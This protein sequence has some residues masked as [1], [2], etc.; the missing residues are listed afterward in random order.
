MIQ[1]FRLQC[2]LE[3]ML[4]KFLQITPDSS[5]NMGSLLSLMVRGYSN[6][7]AGDLPNFNFCCFDICC[8]SICCATTT[9]WSNSDSDSISESKD[10]LRNFYT[11]LWD[12][13]KVPWNSKPFSI[14]VP[15]A[16]PC[17]PQQ[18]SASVVISSCM[19]AITS[20]NVLT[21]LSHS[22]ILLHN[23]TTSQSCALRLATNNHP[24]LHGNPYTAVSII[25]G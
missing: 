16:M 19:M 12:P 18:C 7:S 24:N 3:L 13:M 5:K 2:L 25:W 9:P 21:T 15:S 10:S 8:Q 23:A 17:S 22:L 6:S 20:Y 14:P 4:L 11:V 1:N